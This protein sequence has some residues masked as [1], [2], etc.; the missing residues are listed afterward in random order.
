MADPGAVLLTPGEFI[1]KFLGDDPEPICKVFMR[2]YCYYFALILK[3]AFGR[4][5]I[6]WSYPSAHIVWRDIDEICW[7]IRGEYKSDNDILPVDFNSMP[8]LKGLLHNT[9]PEVYPTEEDIQR[10]KE[11]PK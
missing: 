3:E 11:L 6:C 7:D 2:G 4:G 9:E 1:E 8:F 5:E 10:I